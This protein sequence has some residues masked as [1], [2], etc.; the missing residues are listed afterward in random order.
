MVNVNN[1]PKTEVLSSQAFQGLGP[2]WRLSLRRPRQV[3]LPRIRVIGT[4]R[5]VSPYAI[6]PSCSHQIFATWIHYDFLGKR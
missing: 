2:S 1:Q 6:G 4:N 5:S 3:L